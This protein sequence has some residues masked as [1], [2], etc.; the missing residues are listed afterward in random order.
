MQTVCGAP[1]ND[2]AHGEVKAINIA[3][4]MEKT[5]TTSMRIYRRN[6]KEG[7]CAGVVSWVYMYTVRTRRPD[8]AVHKSKRKR[9]IENNGY[10]DMVDVPNNRDENQSMPIAQT[11]M[12]FPV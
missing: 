8:N 11:T 1:A 5:N 10:Y 3:M 4:V 7:M 12:S 9:M 6:G 2:Q